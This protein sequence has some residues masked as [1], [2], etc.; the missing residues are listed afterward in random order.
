MNSTCQTHREFDSFYIVLSETL[1]HIALC[2]HCNHFRV[3]HIAHS[4]YCEHSAVTDYTVPVILLRLMLNTISLL[5]DF[6][7]ETSCF[8]LMSL[9]CMTQIINL[10]IYHRRL[11]NLL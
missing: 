3:A 2:N 1:N 5:L 7:P 4:V 11:I 8:L 6:C 9:Q 10:S